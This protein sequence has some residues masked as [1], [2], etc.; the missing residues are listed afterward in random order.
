MVV[1]LFAP[2]GLRVLTWSSVSG[3]INVYDLI[4]LRLLDFGR[5][6]SDFHLGVLA[7]I[8]SP[9]KKRVGKLMERPVASP[10]P[11]L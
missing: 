1:A 7:Q 3:S 5:I 10:L 2:S 9:F 8:D 11:L 4:C 6:D